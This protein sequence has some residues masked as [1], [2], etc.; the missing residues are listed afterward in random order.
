MA[1]ILNQVSKEQYQKALDKFASLLPNVDIMGEGWY[2]VA[3]STTNL[4]YSVTFG[5]IDG[6]A[7]VECECPAGKK[8]HFCYHAAGATALYKAHLEGQKKL[9]TRAA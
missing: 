6:Q 8:N 1:V 7:A 3:S 9:A 2:L 4:T 5:K